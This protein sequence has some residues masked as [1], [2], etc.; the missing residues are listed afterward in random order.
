METIELSVMSFDASTRGPQDLMAEFEAR[1]R[2]RV[3]LTQLSWE[4]AWAQV[5]KYALYGDAP[6]VSEIGSTWVASLAAMNA[7]RPF[8]AHEL[9]AFGGEPAF[10][11]TAW[12]SG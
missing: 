7:L 9:L 11:R 12:H 10:L 3:H 5:V 8:T 4:D 6:A 2:V 1:Y